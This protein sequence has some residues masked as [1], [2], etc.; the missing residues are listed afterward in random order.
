MYFTDTNGIAFVQMT[1][2]IILTVIDTSLDWSLASFSRPI[3][4]TRTA[5]GNRAFFGR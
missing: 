1:S 3:W 2:A 5:E 4:P